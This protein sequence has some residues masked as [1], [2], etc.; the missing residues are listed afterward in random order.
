MRAVVSDIF[1]EM[2]R[3]YSG[4]CQ[5]TFI[6]DTAVLWNTFASVVEVIR[7]SFQQLKCTA[8]AWLRTPA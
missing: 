3:C 2:P 7:M 1:L 8:H 6:H 4:R 5:R